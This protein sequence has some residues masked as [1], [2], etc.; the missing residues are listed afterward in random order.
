MN[1]H[2]KKGLLSF[3]RRHGSC[4]NKK[5]TVNYN[6]SEGRVADKIRQ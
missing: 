3:G 1:A 2:E 6:G 4:D 5:E